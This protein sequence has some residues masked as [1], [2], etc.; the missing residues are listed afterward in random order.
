MGSFMKYLM[1]VMLGLFMFVA[2]ISYAGGKKSECSI[3]KAAV[4]SARKKYTPEEQAKRFK[5]TAANYEKK[6]AKLKAAG[7]TYAATAL[8]KK[9]DAKRMMAKAVA[10]GDKK[11]LKKARV[12]FKAANKE[13]KATACYKEEKK[14]RD[15]KKK[16]K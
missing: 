8:K 2:G 5:K 1:F 11:M 4:F 10:A 13:Y 15:A 3:K 12:A 9:A 16:S 6:A 7:K 14:K